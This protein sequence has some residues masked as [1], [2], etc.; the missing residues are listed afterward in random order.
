MTEQTSFGGLAVADPRTAAP[1]PDFADDTTGDDSRRKLAVVG[2]I[3]AVLVV[4]IAAF[5]LMK[6]KGDS[7][8]PAT[9]SAVPPASTGGAHAKSAAKPAKAVTLPKSFDGNVGRDPFKPL[10]VEKA[11]KDA[12]TATTSD[13]TGSATDPTTT[14]V[15]TSPDTTTPGATTTPVTP[16]STTP[17]YRPVWIK[18]VSVSNGA[19]R[20]EVGFSNHKTLKVRNYKLDAPAAGAPELFGRNFALLRVTAHTVT[21]QYGDGTPFT[22]DPVHNVMIVN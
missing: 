12:S 9:A 13:T 3:V 4:L 6:G 17:V 16:V 11:G 14:P 7:A 21:L 2:A 20:F 15:T 19:A 1:A 22:L 18:L 10:F 8:A 5:F